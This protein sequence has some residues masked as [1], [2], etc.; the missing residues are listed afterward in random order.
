M[1]KCFYIILVVL[2]AALLAFSGCKKD[3]PEDGSA[4]DAD[5][6]GMQV[7]MSSKNV[8]LTVYDFAQSYNSNEY[9]QY[10]GY[11]L[12][13]KEQYRDMIINELTNMIYLVNAAYDAG[14]E[15]T[16][17]E[18][19]Q[20]EE[21]I[22]SQIEQ[23]LQSY[24]AKVPE[25]ASDKRAEAIKL[26]NADMENEGINYVAL[27]ELATKNLCMRM[28][29]S[30]YY[31]DLSDSV[32]V[33]DEDVEEYVKAQKSAQTGAAFED[34]SEAL[35]NYFNGSGPYPVVFP[36]D[37][38]SVNHIYLAFS[39][40]KLTD[41]KETYDRNSKKEKEQQIEE[42]LADTDDFDGFMDIVKYHGEDPG[43]SYD[44]FR[45]NGY[46]IHPS[47][48]KSYFPGFVYAAMNLHDGEWTPE[49]DAGYALPEL[50]YFTL[51]DGT[52][53]V[54]VYTESGVH[55]I[56]VN[57]EYSKGEVSYEKGDSFWNSWKE[58]VHSDKMDE[59]LE[60]LNEQW[61]EAYPIEINY[62]LINEKFVN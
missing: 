15:L 25:S 35:T 62:D 28:V 59:M 44:S 60:E 38:F 8:D 3:Q 11:G 56:I 53:V 37:C 26:L 27:V 10:V 22:N 45:E 52:K 54:K 36:D 40:V 6:P 19:E 57:K 29:A 16:D 7:V 32:V 30:K 34:I 1:K 5:L 41:D 61:V 48:D 55:Y 51:K 4:A 2:M 49:P 23:I 47:M 9:Y 33:T 24:M 46:L 39:K 12:I 50:T 18:R 21:T 14:V 43:M 58:A 31:T 20:V 17:E 42:L 13:S